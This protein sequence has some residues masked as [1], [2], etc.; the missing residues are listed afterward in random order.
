MT[1]I[2]D[3]ILLHLNIGLARN[4][5]KYL[6]DSGATQSFIT[7]QW[8]SNQGVEVVTNFS[9]IYTWLISKQ[10]LWLELVNCWQQ[11]GPLRWS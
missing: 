4:Q 2:L 10:H 7:S 6:L 1:V 3:H 5:T 9:L 8:C 11:W